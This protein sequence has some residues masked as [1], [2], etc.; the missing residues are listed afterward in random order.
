MISAS[1]MGSVENYFNLS[2]ILLSGTKSQDS[3]Q[4]HKKCVFFKAAIY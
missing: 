2:L 4:T 3:I 1:K